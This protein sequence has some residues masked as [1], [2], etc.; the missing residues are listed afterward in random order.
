M[1]NWSLKKKAKKTNYKSYES[2]ESLTPMPQGMT[3][4]W[5]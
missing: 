1:K 4:L 2:Y 3:P 5:N